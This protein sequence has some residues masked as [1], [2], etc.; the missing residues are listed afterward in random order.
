MEVEHHI[1]KLSFHCID[2]LVQKC[3]AKGLILA[4]L[5][6]SSIRFSVFPQIKI[7]VFLFELYWTVFGIHSQLLL[8]FS[9]SSSLPL[10]DSDLCF[11][12]GL[13]VSI[14]SGRW[15]G[16]NLMVINLVLFWFMPLFAQFLARWTTAIVR[17]RHVARHHHSP[18]DKTQEHTALHFTK[19]H[20]VALH[21][22]ALHWIK[23]HC[24]RFTS[25]WIEGGWK[26]IIA[27]GWSRKLPHTLS[28]QFDLSYLHRLKSKTYPW[29]EFGSW[30]VCSECLL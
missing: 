8:A 5:Y 1:W 13:W 9:L 17:C 14:T 22:I 12:L 21:Y 23:P 16:A 4:L 19:L 18:E 10:L 25:H 27:P 24:M 11:P 30:C 15:N 20:S 7:Y 28:S 26:S 2:Q 29:W 3:A 6:T